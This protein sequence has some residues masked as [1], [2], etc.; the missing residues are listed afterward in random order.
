M[1]NCVF[2]FFGYMFRSEIAGSYDSPTFCFVRNL[3]TVF[4]SSHTNIHSHQQ[5]RRVPFSPHSRQYLLF[6]AFLVI[7]IL[8]YVKQYLI[9]VLVCISLMISNVEHLFTYPLVICM[10]SL[11][12]CLLRSSAH[13]KI[14]FTFFILNCMS[15]LYA[16][17][18]NPFLIISFA[19][20]SS[21]SVDCLS[22]CVSGFFGCAKAFKFT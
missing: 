5:C 1:L 16:L 4:H 6:L 7:A 2:V 15:Y 20:I 19:N 22:N 21:H 3:H 9:V 8:T 14:G 17:D 10:S 18:I 12:K 13:F 11:E